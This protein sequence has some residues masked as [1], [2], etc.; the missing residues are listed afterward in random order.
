MSKYVYSTL[1][2][3]Y[4]Y[5]LW[6]RPSDV[7]MGPEVISKVFI[8]GGANNA[9]KKQNTPLGVRTEITDAQYEELQQNT[10]FKRHVQRGFIVVKDSKDDP[11]RVAQKNMEARDHSA[12]YTPKSDIFKDDTL[13]TAKP[14]TLDGGIEQRF[15]KRKKG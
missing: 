7:N 2:N 12:P 1:T 5:R 9:D 8:N 11:D 13:E 4:E 14:S 15:S 10:T 3:S 6:T